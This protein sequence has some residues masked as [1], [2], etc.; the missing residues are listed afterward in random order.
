[1]AT[2]SSPRAGASA[3]IVH[4]AFLL[5]REAAA[6]VIRV[7][8]ET[9]PQLTLY[10]RQ[11]RGVLADTLRRDDFRYAVDLAAAAPRDLQRGAWSDRQSLSYGSRL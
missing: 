7:H 2:G 11:I 8:D 9:M 3:E 4:I 10:T 5:S 1:M 6:H